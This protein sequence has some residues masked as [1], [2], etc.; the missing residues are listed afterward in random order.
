MLIIGASIGIFLCLCCVGAVLIFNTSSTSS[1]S[2]STTEPGLPDVFSTDVQVKYVVTGSATSASVTY[3]NEQG[4]ME[5]VD[6]N[7]PWEKAMKVPSGSA[8]SL[9]AQNSGSGSITCEIWENGE[10]K[11]TSTSTAQYGVVT[12]TDFAQ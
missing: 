11:K 6:M 9:V 12:C 8:L 7:I 10:K 2:D 3:F 1:S 4:G 5:Q